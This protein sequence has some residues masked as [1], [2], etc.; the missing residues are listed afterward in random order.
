MIA[1]SD[2]D[3]SE[4]KDHTI[5]NLNFENMP[6]FSYINDSLRNNISDNIF[7]LFIKKIFT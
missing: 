1:F 5:G 7:S 4:K 6:L 2:L 3:D